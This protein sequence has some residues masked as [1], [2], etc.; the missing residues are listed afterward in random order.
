MCFRKHVE[1][2]RLAKQIKQ[3][4]ETERQAILEKSPFVCGFFQ[5]TGY[6]VFLKDEPDFEKA[7]VTG[8][9]QVYRETAEDWIIRQY[10]LANHENRA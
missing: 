10:L 6:D 5:G 4:S 7:Y 3:L 2:R 1:N 9:G 8:L